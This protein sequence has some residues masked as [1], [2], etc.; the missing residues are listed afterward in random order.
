MPETFPL[1]DPIQILAERA[2]AMRD[3]LN[4]LEATYSA[5]GFVS[6]EQVLSTANTY[7]AAVEK[8]HDD[9]AERG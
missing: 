3:L 9:L 7:V 2:T 8:M 6:V 5:G 4:S 1:M